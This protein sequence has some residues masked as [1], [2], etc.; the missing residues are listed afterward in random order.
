MTMKLI[1]AK[2][3][4]DSRS[5]VMFDMGNGK[6]V[7]GVV[8]IAQMSNQFGDTTLLKAARYEG[9]KTS[10][11]ELHWQWSRSLKTED[12]EKFL[13]AI[14]DNNIDAEFIEVK[15]IEHK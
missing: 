8:I 2:A 10:S 4:D 5:A 14:L 13:T 3:L 12:C 7:G 1:F 11:L 9:I 15:T 6:I